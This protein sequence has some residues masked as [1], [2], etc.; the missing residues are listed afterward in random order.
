MGFRRLIWPHNT[1]SQPVESKCLKDCRISLVLAAVG[2]DR[3]SLPVLAFLLIRVDEAWIAMKGG[4][5]I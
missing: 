4:T 1:C 3:G 5:T 2:D